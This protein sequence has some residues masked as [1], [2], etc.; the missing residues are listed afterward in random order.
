M[1][2]SLFCNFLRNQPKH[3]HL[4]FIPSAEVGCEFFWYFYQEPIM[5]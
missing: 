5:W 3:T 2:T 1:K 4:L